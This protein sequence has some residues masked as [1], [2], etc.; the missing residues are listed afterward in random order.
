MTQNKKDTYLN[1]IIG[2]F[3]GLDIRTVSDRTKEQIGKTL[4]DYL[5]CAQYTAA[6]RNAEPLIRLVLDFG[7]PGNVTV[8]GTGKRSNPASAAMANACRTSNIEMDDGSGINAAVHPGVYVWSAALAAYEQN[9]C[10][11]ETLM[12][13]AL[14]GYELCMRVGMLAARNVFKHELHGPG[15]NGAFGAVAAAGMVMGLTEDEMRSAIGMAGSLLPVC[16]FVS[17]VKGT[18]NKD[19]YGGWSVYLGVVS[20]EAAKRGMTGPYDI[21]G[22]EKSL[23]HVFDDTWGMDMPIGE[24]GYLIEQIGFKQYPSCLAVHPSLSALTALKKEYGF[25][26]EEIDHIE[27]GMHHGGF[28]LTDGVEFPLT[29]VSARLYVPYCLTEFLKSG[30]LR[31]EPFTEEAIAGADRDMLARKVRVR[32]KTEYAEKYPGKTCGDVTVVLK[33]GRTYGREVIGVPWCEKKATKQELIEKFRM[34]T[35]GILDEKTRQEQ[36]KAVFEFD[37]KGLAKIL[38]R[39]AL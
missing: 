5:G 24:N 14:F 29:P 9:P 6:H 10:S 17:F 35:D 38:D 2:H 39:L 25:D 7:A 3:Y 33:D 26:P 8:F 31:P 11:M 34:L 20:A 30:A 18:D 16:P 15:M 12:K 27:V 36:L 4:L 32:E 28:T 22:D 13:A 19:M 23:K 37:R 1:K 21:L